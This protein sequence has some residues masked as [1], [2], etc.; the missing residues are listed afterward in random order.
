MDSEGKILHEIYGDHSYYDK[1]EWNKWDPYAKEYTWYDIIL[2]VITDKDGNYD[3]EYGMLVMYSKA[4][5]DCN[6]IYS[7]SDILEFKN[8]NGWTNSYCND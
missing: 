6:F 8:R 7:A 5:G 4:N 3:K 1:L 2:W